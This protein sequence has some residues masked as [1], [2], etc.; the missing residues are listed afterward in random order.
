MPSMGGMGGQFGGLDF[1]NVQGMGN[2]PA[3]TTSAAASPVDPAVRFA[4]QIVQL[5]E[6]GFSDDARSLILYESRYSSFLIIY[7]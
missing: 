1:S 6:M 2:T 5:H 7:L 4:S 3:T